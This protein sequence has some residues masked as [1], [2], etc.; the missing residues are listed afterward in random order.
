[1][2]AAATYNCTCFGHLGQCDKNRNG[3]ISVVLPKV[4]NASSH[5]S[6]SLALSSKTLPMRSNWLSHVYIG[7][8]FIDNVLLNNASDSNV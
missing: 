7:Y 5:V 6:L 8:V 3:P 4:A 1:M 2:P